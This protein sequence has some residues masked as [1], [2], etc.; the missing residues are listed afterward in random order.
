GGE[1]PSFLPNPRP[2]TEAS[3]RQDS[4]WTSEARRAF[5]VNIVR[6]ASSSHPKV[7][8]RRTRVWENHGAEPTNDAEFADCLDGLAPLW[9]H[10]TVKR[11]LPKVCADQAS[12]PG[13]GRVGRT[14][15]FEWP[16]TA[17]ARFLKVCVR[18]GV[19]EDTERG[20]RLASS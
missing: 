9:D 8:D 13:C 18:C 7:A 1:C 17:R 16:E 6:V 10:W 4:L 2:V 12:C 5:L 14:F 11:P 15:A 19:F 3:E 20:S